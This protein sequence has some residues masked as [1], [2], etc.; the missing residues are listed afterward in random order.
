[1]S[2]VGSFRL[3]A[4][5]PILQAMR[6]SGLLLT[7]LGACLLAGRG[8]AQQPEQLPTPSFTSSVDVVSVDVNVV[9]RNGRPVR[10]LGADDFTLA[11]DGRERRIAS[12]QFVPFDAPAEPAKSPV[13]EYVTNAPTGGRLVA[14]VID[15]GSIAPVR[16]RDV[17]SA[18]ARFVERL[19][20][21][22]RV[23]L[24]T[25]PTGPLID[26]TTDHRAVSA[27]LQQ[28]DGQ[29]DLQR[30]ALK[31][32]GVAEALQ[33]ER[34]NTIAIED[35][36]NREC[37]TV[38]G[39][40]SQSELVICRRTVAEE[41]SIVATYAH[42]RARNTMAGLRAILDRL[43]SGATPKTL[44][45]VSEGLVIEG[46]RRVIDG[47]AHAAAAAH[48]T[49]YVLEP[50]PSETDASQARP[51]FSRARD[52]A[53]REEGLQFVSAVGGGELFRV[54]ADPDYAFARV[55]SELSGYYLLGFEP[56]AGDRDGKSHVI[57]VK[58]NRDH[59]SLRSRREFTLAPPGRDAKEAITRLLRTPIV[60]TGI[61]LALTSYVFQDP[62]TLRIRLLVA[63]DIEDTATQVGAGI[64]LIDKKG[65]VGASFYQPEITTSPSS[66]PGT[67]RYFATLLL[68]PGPYT[69]RAA[70]LDGAGR[71]GSIE[72]SVWAY[73]RRLGPFRVTELLLGDRDGSG[74]HATVVPSVTGE[75]SGPALHTYLELFSE[76]P[77]VFA[78]T[79]V[80]M[81]VAAAEDAPALASA[82]AT[83]QQPDQNP[84][85]RAVAAA[86]TLDRLLPGSYVA[87]AVISVG[88]KKV[89]EMTRG[90]RV[91]KPRAA[92]AD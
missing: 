91:V 1:M 73:M 56:E 58:V 62:G 87:R 33:F 23:A 41:A 9:D 85:N 75:A 65:A 10:D 46:E 31:S 52:R 36:T 63:M 28:I 27:A 51:P 82:P 68:E 74:D 53:T 64:V 17:L 38:A 35:V 71:R 66:P 81:E 21:G 25:I 2:D 60:E 16:A 13:P 83:L 70:V 50:Q 11:V 72:T 6:G 45:L 80:V 44:L 57:S 3:H 14:L 84:Q 30:G 59:V 78:Q 67:R 43:G 48:A 12:A 54:V 89:G 8:A 86:V 77:A 5:A 40:S 22:D 76:T 34:N 79:S 49:L 29:A 26:F 55:A 19:G 90:F 18:A 47:F 39:N 42:E 69:L 92:P 24:F 88:G 20:P 37:G 4:E 15:R 7:I 61:P 32:I